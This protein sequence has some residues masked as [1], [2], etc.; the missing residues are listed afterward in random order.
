[1][2][3][4]K[5]SSACSVV[6]CM[7]FAPLGSTRRLGDH[8][9]KGGTHWKLQMSM[10]AESGRRV[11]TLHGYLIEVCREEDISHNSGADITATP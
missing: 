4:C 7:T 8:N 10:E 5:T 3:V 6:I 11:H 9:I 2:E 1:M